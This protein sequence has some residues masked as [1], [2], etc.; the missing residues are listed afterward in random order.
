MKNKDFN[1]LIKDYKS[2]PIPKEL[3]SV[4]QNALIKS[5][6]KIN[7]RTT[8]YRRFAPIA[9][10]I[11]AAAIILTAGINSSPAFA[12]TLS[13][14]PVVGSIVKVLTFKNYTVNEDKYKADIKVPEVTGL[15]NKELE[16]SLNEKYLAE[17]KKLYDQFISDMKNLKEADGGHLGINSGYVVKTDTDRIL[18]IGRYVVNTVGSSST[19]VKYDTVDKK[20]EV[21]IT[22]PS[23]FKDDRYMGIISQNIK[24]QMIEQH[25]LDRNKF[26]WVKGIEQKSNVELFKQISKNQNFYINSAG[27][28]V[29]SFDKY[30]VAPGYMGVVEFVIPT[31]VLSDTLVSNEYIK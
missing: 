31:E 1:R 17:N 8:M 22:L 27:K 7:K 28:L 9:A 26:Y 30:E 23:L 6:I 2:V 29:I 3:D 11:A 12:K 14:V 18:S 21:L 19:T 13:E 20:N 10:S 16:R 4:V 15:Q 25:K 5:G 24:E